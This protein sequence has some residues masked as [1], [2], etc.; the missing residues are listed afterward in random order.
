MTRIF[1]TSLCPNLRTFAKLRGMSL[2]E[3][4]TP[5]ISTEEGRSQRVKRR[6]WLNIALLFSLPLVGGLNLLFWWW[7][8]PPKP[9]ATVVTLAIAGDSKTP[10]RTNHEPYGVA[11]DEDGNIFFSDS[12]TGRIYLIPAADYSAQSI[13]ENK[14]IIA[15]GF[16]T[17]SA[18]ALDGDGNLIVANTGAHTIARIDFKTNKWSVIAG[19]DGES[20]LAD[21]QGGAARFN[22][23]VGLAVS[24]DGT[25][26]VADTYNDRIR[27]ISRD[28]EVRTLA[29]GGDPGLRDGAGAEARFD[30][31]CGIAIAQDGTLLVADTGNNRIRRVAPDG[32]VTTYAGAGEASDGAPFVSGFYRPAAIAVLDEDAF[33]VADALTVRLC[34]FGERQSIKPLTGGEPF[35]MFDDDLARARLNRPSGLT[36]LPGGQLVFTDSGNGLVRAIV[37]ADAKIGGRADA[38]S[39]ILPPNKLLA[40]LEPRWPYDPPQ[41]RRDIAGTFGEIRGELL[42][43]QTA[44]F[45]TGIDVPG[46]YGETVR[47]VITEKVLLPLAVEDPGDGRERLRLPLFEYIHLRIGRDQN[48]QPIGN[49]AGGAITFR[50]DEVNGIIGVRVRRGTRINAGDQIGTLNSLNHVHLVAGP[51]ASEVNALSVL[52]LPG[53]TDTVP[54]VI[55]GVAILNELNE[56]AY[57]TGKIAE[58]SGKLR[59]AA[60]VYDRIDGN[61]KYRR[62]GVYRLGYQVL[63]TNGS[64]A[65]G[66]NEPRYNI[67]FDRLPAAPNAVLLAFADGSQS[68]YS[69]ATVFN[70]LVTNVVRGGDARA[71]FWNASEL[72]PGEYKLRV[73]AEDHFG[74][75]AQRDVSVRVTARAAK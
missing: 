25:I 39:I 11:A 72:E 75:Q 7:T 49:F 14:T 51:P 37:P 4:R 48:E 60:Q 38:R 50:R 66:F 62:L 42:S 68:G 13:S 12:V 54:P 31:P 57:V 18:I 44:W 6:R 1:T 23:P 28:G 5:N 43:D 15:E 55:E 41:A 20:G 61:P 45:H 22:G 59:I 27:A 73:I 67:V 34:T 58:V 16:D 46:A 65:P 26:F 69:G 21:G 36:L 70:Y 47:A 33:Y 24:D 53:L 9:L 10:I 2:L 32:D 17:P 3:A 8:R 29:G 52:R 19:R 71:D 56:P 63:K 74:N 35:G 40:R 30:T 64:P